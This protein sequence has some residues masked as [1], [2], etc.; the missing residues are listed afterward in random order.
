MPTSK[1][2][3]I[4]IVILLCMIAL[5]YAFVRYEIHNSYVNGLMQSGPIHASFE[6]EVFG[7]QESKR[8]HQFWALWAQRQQRDIGPE[9]VPFVNDSYGGIQWNAAR[10]FALLEDPSGEKPLVDLLKTKPEHF[11]ERL[12][13][14]QYFALGRIRSRHQKGK[15]KLQT[16][17]KELN[18]SWADVVQMS[19]K[20]NTDWGVYKFR[21]SA[22]YQV[23]VY[24]AE[25]LYDMRRRGDNVDNLVAE[26]TLN[27]Q[28]K[29]MLKGATLPIEKETD[30]IFDWAFLN[31]AI[32]SNDEYLYNNHFP[33]LAPKATNHLLAKMNDVLRHPEKCPDVEAAIHQEA[34]FKMALA[35]NDKR[36][37]PVFRE[38]EKGKLMGPIAG[39]YRMYLEN[40]LKYG[41]L[42]PL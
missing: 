10:A 24:V 15:A 9:L 35:T 8:Q 18:L 37:I 2:P 40:Q 13:I 21:S 22:G 17:L 34:L 32:D 5:V 36:F 41:L 39:R 27:R 19:K 3:K 38:F 30:L 1:A 31:T 7:P 20:L 42:K 28:Q 16:I 12:R 23:L 29:I 11:D 25:V 33:L 14:A 4:R 6:S 26:V